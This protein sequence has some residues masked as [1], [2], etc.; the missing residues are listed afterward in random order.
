MDKNEIVNVFQYFSHKLETFCETYRAST[1]YN[2]LINNFG[3]VYKNIKYPGN[4][5]KN[6]VGNSDDS[7]IFLEM[8]DKSINIE[9]SLINKLNFSLNCSTTEFISK[10]IYG[11]QSKSKMFEFDKNDNYM[12]DF[13]F[14]YKKE[15]LGKA[16]FCFNINDIQRITGKSNGNELKIYYESQLDYDEDRDSSPEALFEVV[17]LIEYPVN[18]NIN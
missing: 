17:T 1:R 3:C 11:L 9:Q 4:F 2:C 13:S 15:I 12:F 6:N 10:K 18:I 5:I 16:I 14:G 8:L 7:M